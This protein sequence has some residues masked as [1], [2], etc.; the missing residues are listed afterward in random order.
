MT[1]TIATQAARFALAAS[2]LFILALAARS[3]SASPR[4]REPAPPLIVETAQGEIFDLA[5]MRGKVV[6]V[7]FWATW[8]APCLR[9][10]PA[11]GD[12]HQK[13]RAEGFEVIALS[14]DEP[15]N[16]RKMMTLLSKLPF[17]GALFSD[18]TES[19]FEKPAAVP[20]SYLVDA[21]GVI[22]DTFLNVDEDLLNET[23]PPLLKQARRASSAEPGTR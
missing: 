22:R 16:R 9:E 8:C 2:A 7:N 1:H 19:G 6:L 5:A 17:P 4:L 15:R 12:F 23:V 13:H 14:I 10:L 11:I 3:V 20:V 21:S 18:A